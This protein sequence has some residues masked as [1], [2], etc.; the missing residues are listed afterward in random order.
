MELIRNTG[1]VNNFGVKV[2]LFKKGI[3]NGQTNGFTTL[4]PLDLT[5]NNFPNTFNQVWMCEKDRWSGWWAVGCQ[6]S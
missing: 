6:L 1:A 2:L 3:V 4:V 5:V